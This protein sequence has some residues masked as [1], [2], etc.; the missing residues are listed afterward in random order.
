[1]RVESN[2]EPRN[3]KQAKQSTHNVRS[4][5]IGGTPDTRTNSDGLVEYNFYECVG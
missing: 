4:S 2:D 1:M 5:A 3:P